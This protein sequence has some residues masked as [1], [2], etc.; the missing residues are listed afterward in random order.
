MK[1]IYFTEELEP[2]FE[3]ISKREKGALQAAFNHLYRSGYVDAIDEATNHVH[4]LVQEMKKGKLDKYEE[5]VSLSKKKLLD[6]AGVFLSMEDTARAMIISGA[7]LIGTMRDII[8]DR[9]FG[10]SYRLEREG[11]E[12]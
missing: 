2:V 9:D 11:E 8:E 10:E 5:Y 12:S 6:D 3:R 4:G 1:D 7:G